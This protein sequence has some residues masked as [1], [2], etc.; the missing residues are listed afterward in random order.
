ME[1]ILLVHTAALIYFLFNEPTLEDKIF[2]YVL[3]IWFEYFSFYHK[4]KLYLKKI[5]SKKFEGNVAFKLISF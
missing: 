4:K 2:P 1:S 3:V 5:I